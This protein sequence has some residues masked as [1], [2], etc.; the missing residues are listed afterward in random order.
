MIGAT[1]QSNPTPWAPLLIK[2]I[3]GLTPLS[4]LSC[5]GPGAGV[6]GIPHCPM[7]LFFFLRTLHTSTAACIGPGICGSQGLDGGDV[8]RLP[9][10]I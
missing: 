4:I 3:K 5:Q 1:N 2:S 10:V 8:K 7:V 6:V 9:R